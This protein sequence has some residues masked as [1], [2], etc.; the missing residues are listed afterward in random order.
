MNHSPSFDED[1]Y[2]VE[3]NDPRFDPS[4]KNPAEAGKGVRGLG[5]KIFSRMW[6]P[7]AQGDLEA[8]MIW[9]SRHLKNLATRWRISPLRFLNKLIS[10]SAIPAFW[11]LIFWA[12]ATYVLE[13]KVPN[14]CYLA[15]FMFAWT[16]RDAALC[17]SMRPK[18]RELVGLMCHQL[19]GYWMSYCVGSI[20]YLYSLNHPDGG[21]NITKWESFFV[22]GFFYLIIIGNVANRR[23]ASGLIRYLGQV[24]MI[25]GSTLAALAAA[26]GIFYAFDFPTWKCQGWALF[27][28]GLMSFWIAV[29]QFYKP[30]SETQE[31]RETAEEITK[32]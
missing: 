30:S 22:G 17:I 3:V 26:Y 2:R 24:A 32:E 28:G 27:C 19:A 14:S 5:K 13:G 20:F 12:F 21:H 10:L 25:A 7:P 4:W 29:N 15:T 18:L 6:N 23:G 11:S 8:P 31:S 16:L 9:S 1:F